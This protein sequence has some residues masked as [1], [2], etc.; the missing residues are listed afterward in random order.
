M[1]QLSAGSRG[2]GAACFFALC[3]ARGCK[4]VDPGCPASDVGVNVIR[5]S[6]GSTAEHVGNLPLLPHGTSQASYGPFSACNDFDGI[7][8]LGGPAALDPSDSYYVKTK[9]YRQGLMMFIDH[10]NQERGGLAVGGRRRSR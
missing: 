6:D 3:V 1:K 2:F 5:A 7:I 8:V 9:D 4:G 10:V